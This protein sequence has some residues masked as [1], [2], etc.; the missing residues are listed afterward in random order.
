MILLPRLNLVIITPGKT[1]STALRAELKQQQHGAI[2][3][4]G[5]QGGGA[6]YHKHTPHVPLALPEGMRS[7]QVAVT[8]RNPFDRAVSLWKHYCRYGDRKVSFRQFVEQV[9]TNHGSW[10]FF[11]FTIADTLEG[12]HFDHIIRVESLLS[13]L[14]GL[15]INIKHLP[16][17]HSHDTAEPYRRYYDQAV[18]DR[19]RQWAQEDFQL[20]GYDADELDYLDC[21][22][23]PIDPSGD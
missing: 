11:R 3:L 17:R 1:A 2:L 19:V 14:Q 5:P 22:S 21:N 23:P 15:G 4:H 9:L 8:V 13:D 20:F 6:D 16:V 10:W 18:R 7:P 12:S